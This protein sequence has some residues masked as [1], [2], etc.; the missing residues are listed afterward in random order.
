MSQLTN[1]APIYIESGILSGI[2]DVQHGFF[3]RQGGVS[4]TEYASLNCGLG[5]GDRPEA[6]IENRRRVVSALGGHCLVTNRQVHGSNVRRIERDS[7][8]ESVPSADGLVTTEP[9][10]C[11]GALGADCA[12][13]VFADPVAQVVGVAHAGWQGALCGVTDTVI[14]AMIEAGAGEA[15]IIVAIGPAI[16]WESY[17]VGDD[18]VARFATESPVDAS[19]CFRSPDPNGSCHFDL[20]GYIRLRLATWNLAG[21]EQ[22]P[23]DTYMDE[24]RF[25]SYRRTCHRGEVRY[26]RQIGAICLV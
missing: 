10:I 18:F 6:V 8:L 24:D 2:P 21:I 19:G 23:H 15:D 13:V 11:L 9:G 1:T 25:F 26:G 4:E 5:S 16:Q 14:S 7:N 3:T 22:L 20:T 12:P 17:E